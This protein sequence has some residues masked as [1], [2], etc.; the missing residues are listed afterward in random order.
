MPQVLIEVSWLPTINRGF[1][2]R[3]EY[4]KFWYCFSRRQP[5]GPI[6]SGNLVYRLTPKSLL[7]FFS[8]GHFCV[9]KYV[10]RVLLERLKVVVLWEPHAQDLTRKSYTSVLYWLN[11]YFLFP[12]SKNSNR[13]GPSVPGEGI[14]EDDMDFESRR[15]RSGDRFALPNNDHMRV[16]RNHNID[17]PPGMY[18]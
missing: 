10:K 7:N 17:P 14:F 6:A 12:I 4:R 13:F 15:P 8:S 1:R 2:R 11:L 16:P 3:L 18:F 5:H 9:C